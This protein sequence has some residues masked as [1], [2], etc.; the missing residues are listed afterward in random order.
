MSF[1]IDTEAYK[2]PLEKLLEL[3]EEKKLEITMVSLARVTG[4]FL[5]YMESL[6]QAQGIRDGQDQGIKGEEDLKSIIADFLVVASRLLLIKSRVLLPNLDLD[7]EE[8]GDIRD[9]E[10]RLKLY[11]ELKGAKEHIAKGWNVFP[12][13][14]SREFLATRQIVFSP[15]HALKLFDLE[16]EMGKVLGELQRFLLPT[17]KIENTMIK[18]QDTIHRLLERMSEHPMDL[19]HLDGGKPR[20]EVVALFL[21]VLHLVREHCIWVEQEGE[22]GRIYIR[23]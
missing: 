2:G 13:M 3:V 4:D 22:F 8:E 14:M 18:L 19:G 10:F 5:K 12:R 16:R 21:A 11:E 15:P 6:R 20:A 23:K 7:E 1:S 9:L 17:E